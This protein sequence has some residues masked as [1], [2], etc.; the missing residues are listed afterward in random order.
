[1]RPKLIHYVLVLGLCFFRS[2]SSMA[3]GRFAL[4]IGN[5]N[6]SEQVGKLIN[7][8]N[9]VVLV[10]RALQQ[11]GFNAVVK[12]DL[13]RAEIMEQVA[14]FAQRVGSA[15][16][17]TIGFLY[18][19]GHGVSRPLDRSNYL[20]PID[21][22]SLQDQSFWWNAVPLDTILNELQNAAPKA[23]FIV[24]FDACRNELHIPTKSVT[25]GFEPVGDKSGIFV[26]FATSP[27]MSSSDVGDGGGPY[28]RILASELTRPG[29]DHLT[30]FQN[31]KERVFAA[32]DSTQRP[33][34]NNGLLER[35]YLAGQPTP[36]NQPVLSDEAKRVWEIF[37]SEQHRHK[38]SREFH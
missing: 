4:L 22:Q 5:E 34:E 29:Q 20:I 13:G 23:S 32:T 6:Y 11:L 19:S 10:A 36:Q 35:V 7:P 33:W 21:I 14:E 16:N 15:D 3:A 28:A 8:H 9:D 12:Q 24:V 38:I 26:A 1:M 18:Y 2:T 25:K 27:N 31:V 17:D 37:C 30:L